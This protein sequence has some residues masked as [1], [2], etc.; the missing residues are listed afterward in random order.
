MKTIPV[1]YKAFALLLLAI[2]GVYYYSQHGNMGVLSGNAGF[3]VIAGTLATIAYQTQRR[4]PQRRRQQTEN[5]RTEHGSADWASVQELGAAG[6]TNKRNNVDDGTTWFTGDFCLANHYHAL[7]VAPSRSGKGASVIIPNLLMQP[8]CSYVLTDPKGELAYI[9]AKWQRQCGQRVY[10]IDPWD[11]QGREGAVHG[12]A[13]SGFNPFDFIKHDPSRIIDNCHQIAELLVPPNP[14]A[15]DPYWDDSARNLIKLCLMH[16]VVSKPHSDHNFWTLYKMLRP[17]GDE[18]VNMIVDMQADEEALDGLISRMSAEYEMGPM[19]SPLRSVLSTAQNATTIFESPELRASLLRSDFNP[20]S[21][22]DGN[23]TVYIVIPYDYL[24]SHARWLRMVVGICIKAA[25]V[26][27][28]HKVKFILDEFGVLGKMDAIG[29]GFQF[30]AGKNIC[31]WPFVQDLGT[32]KKLYGE[33]GMNKFIANASVLQFFNARDSFTA[34]YVSDLLGKKTHEMV[35]KSRTLNSKDNTYST[36]TNTSVYG[37]ELMTPEEVAKDD[38]SIIFYS[39]LK[40][41]LPKNYY[42]NI[43]IFQER[44]CNPPI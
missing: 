4:I 17:K 28:N 15:K 32:L 42:F 31:L 41:I 1:H 24:Q 9:T 3:F 35:N 26:R 6:V 27:V 13:P 21:L 40:A 25:T 44:A 16:I 19:E 2:F 43:P 23:C 14:E 12:I 39:G 18:W 36:T 29:N 22:S 5:K 10:I 38:R 37:R 33:E 34:K 30:L 8:N 11:I 7:T 20:L